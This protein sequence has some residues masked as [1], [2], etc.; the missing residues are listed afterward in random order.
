[1]IGIVSRELAIEASEGV[2][3]YTE[4]SKSELFSLKLEL[5]SFDIY[6]FS[7]KSNSILSTLLFS[8]EFLSRLAKVLDA[9]LNSSVYTSEPTR[10]LVFSMFINLFNKILRQL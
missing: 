1:M 10:Y 9:V 5:L 3:S 8:L 4:G 7:Y 2:S 6:D